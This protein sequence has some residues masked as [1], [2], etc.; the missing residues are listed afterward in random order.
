MATLICRHP[1]PAADLM[2]TTFILHIRDFNCSNCGNGWISSDLYRCEVHGMTTKMEPFNAAP[3]VGCA[4]GT[5]RL[6][7]KTVGVC[8]QCAPS[9]ELERRAHLDLDA[10]TRWKETI[11]RKTLPDHPI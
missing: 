9:M 8:F 1:R 6:P 2:D 11:N 10:A 7:P 5:S 4:F 3:L